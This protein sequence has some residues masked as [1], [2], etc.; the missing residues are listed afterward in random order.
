M[1]VDKVWVQACYS[2]TST[3]RLR[4]EGNQCSIVYHHFIPLRMDTYGHKGTHFSLL[5]T[6][7]AVTQV[8]TGTA[9]VVVVVQVVVVDPQSI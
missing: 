2:T 5:A 3:L 7:A 4:P 9:V 8:T 6:L 1:E